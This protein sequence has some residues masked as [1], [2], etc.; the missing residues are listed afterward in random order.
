MM[1]PNNA[2]GHNVKSA[3]AFASLL[4]RGGRGVMGTATPMQPE[5]SLILYEFEA[6]PYSRRVREVMTLLNL[7]YESR[8]S[9]HKGH[10]YRDELKELAG[11]TQVPF[12][13]DDNIAKGEEGN[14]ILDSQAII[15]HLFANY[16]KK[17]F[18]PDKYQRRSKKDNASIANKA[19]SVASM[20]RGVKAVHPKK[21]LAR[22]KPKAPLHLYGF[23]ASPFCRLVREKLSE[24]EV[25]YINHNVARERLQDI[26]AFGFHL[27]FGE[28]QP[29]KGGKRDRLMTGDLKG[30]LLF[31][32]LVDPNTDAQM[33]ESK[34]IID[35]L[36]YNYG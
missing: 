17:G 25:G 12:L 35:Y 11:T 14:Q 18:T 6:C 22:G 28:Y 27:G 7:D 2:I 34:D 3:Q 24:L 4:L 16:S 10:V 29:I 19:A 23:E 8:P 26:G 5:K 9:P 33:Y 15:D 20:M 36:E 31:P 21:N 1:I 13:I 32:Y 30:K